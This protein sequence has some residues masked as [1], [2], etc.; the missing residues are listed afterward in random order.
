[1]VLALENEL[2]EPFRVYPSVYDKEDFKW[3]KT[4]LDTLGKGHRPQAY[5]DPVC[6]STL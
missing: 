2:I 6:Q 5:S 4:A 1:M 3:Q